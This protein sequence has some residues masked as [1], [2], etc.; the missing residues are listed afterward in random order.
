MPLKML[1][2]VWGIVLTLIALIP[3]AYWA[4]VESKDAETKPEAAKGVGRRASTAVGGTLGVIIAL[5][6]GILGGL[7]QALGS[8]EPLALMA[9]DFVFANPE[10]TA[11]AAITGLGSLGI[12]G[13]LNLQLWEFL[14]GAFIISAIG[15]ALA[16]RQYTTSKNAGLT[17]ERERERE[18][19]ERELFD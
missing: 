8:L 3:L 10:L 9:L 14:L 16:A 7:Y 15:A 13:Y 4:Y 11:N 2:S 12:I 17:T 5:V 6:F 1:L 18:E 19:G